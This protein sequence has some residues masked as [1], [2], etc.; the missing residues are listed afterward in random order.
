MTLQLIHLFFITT[1][2]QDLPSLLHK[3][4]ASVRGIDRIEPLGSFVVEGEGNVKTLLGAELLVLIEAIFYDSGD[5][6][7]ALLTKEDVYLV[8]GV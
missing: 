3:P 4:N 7:D 5:H 1:V 8:V 6:I 2:F